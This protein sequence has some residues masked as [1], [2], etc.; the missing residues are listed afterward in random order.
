MKDSRRGFL[1]KTGLAIAG[2]VGAGTAKPDIAKAQE[3]LTPPGQPDVSQFADDFASALVQIR[4]E[5]IEKLI[6]K[7]DAR[8]R[9]FIAAKEK[10]HNVAY[11]SESDS[12]PMPKE[13]KDAL[14]KEEARRHAQREGQ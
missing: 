4:G 12:L 9:A 14:R 13:L 8:L 11:I 6:S 3:T 7:Q 1:K 2:L 5:R 10:G